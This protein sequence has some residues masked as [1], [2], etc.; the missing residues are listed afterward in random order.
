MIPE[1]D[2]TGWPD[3][4][5]AAEPEVLKWSLVFGATILIWIV[6]I[7]IKRLV[8]LV[9]K[10][11]T[12]KDMDFEGS[13]WDLGASVARMFALILMSPLPLGLAGY[14]WRTLVENRGPGAIAAVAILFVAILFAN[15]VARSMRNFGGKAHRRTGADDTLFAFAGSLVKYLIFAVAIV[16]ALTQ[17]GF[18]T[19]SLAAVLGAL[20]LAI[21]LGLQDTMKSVAAGVMLAILR[22]FRIGDYVSLAGLEGEVTDISPF[23]TSLKQVDNK[24]VIVTNDKVWSDALVNHTRQTRRRFD[25]YF[26]ISYDDNMDHALAVLLAVATDHPRVL[27]KSETWVGVHALADWSV[28]LR[29]RAWVATPEFVQVRADITKGVKEAFD[30]EGISIPYPHQVNVAYKGNVAVNKAEHE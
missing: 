2:M 13:S 3:W 6:A 15:W 14:D 23:T 25:L 30:R 1:I 17:L 9:G 27:A 10:M 5:V 4:A 29:L 18:P 7:V 12:A 21:G 20:G 8:M 22:P 28:K 16:M 19:T 24:I 11:V 26:D